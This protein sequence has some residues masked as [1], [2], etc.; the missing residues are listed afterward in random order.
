MVNTKDV[1]LMCC[2]ICYSQLE[3]LS[4]LILQDLLDHGVT[5]FVKWSYTINK[6]KISVLNINQLAID[7]ITRGD[8]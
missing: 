7:Y 5:P 2:E 3:Q 6:S 1:A 4:N 8:Y